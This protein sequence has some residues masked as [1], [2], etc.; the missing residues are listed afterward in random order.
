MPVESEEY[1]GKIDLQ[2][3]GFKLETKF[4]LANSVVN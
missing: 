3:K 1:L 2:S 4:G